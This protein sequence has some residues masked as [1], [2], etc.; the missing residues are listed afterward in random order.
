MAY[1]IGIGVIIENPDYNRIRD[2]ELNLANA[3][4]SFSGLG[5]PPHV[6]VKRP[7][8]VDGLDDIQKAAKIMDKLAA[9]TKAFKINLEGHKNFSDKVLYLEVV[10]NDHL[11]KIHEQLLAA[12]EPLFP[13][14]TGV[15]EGQKMIFHSTLAMDLSGKQF[16]VAEEALKHYDRKQLAFSV[17]IKKIGL[18]LGIDQETHWVIIKEASLAQAGHFI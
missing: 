2:I 9:S 5:Q 4:G 6:T 3:T 14:S 17:P 7:F 1:T 18:F 10:K 12:L 16:T 11:N 8:V 15:F 13:G